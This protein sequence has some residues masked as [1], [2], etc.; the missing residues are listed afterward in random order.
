V[1]RSGATGGVG[2]MAGGPGEAQREIAGPAVL[3][4]WGVGRG[5]VLL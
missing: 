1:R 2:T 5:R 4:D 3:L